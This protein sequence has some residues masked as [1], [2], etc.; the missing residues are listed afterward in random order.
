MPT[1]F[2]RRYMNPNLFRRVKN[3]V[4]PNLKHLARSEVRVCRA[5]QK[6]SVFLRFSK[7]EEFLFCVRCGANLRY[8]L[9]A[10]VIREL[11]ALGKLDI[12]E[13]DPDSTIRWMFRNARTHLRTY[14]R[15][16]H[17]RGTVREDGARMEDITNLTLA[18]ESVDF[19][20][21]SDVLEHV[22]DANA[23]FRESFRVLRPGGAHIFTVPYQRET[24]QRARI[25]DGQITHIVT[26]PEYHSDPLDPRGI[27]AYWHY[28]P[29]LDLRFGSTS[30]LEFEIVKE[31]EG[32]ANRYVWVA[33]KPSAP[34]I[35]A[36]S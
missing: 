32:I 9:L 2:L 8:E 17:S 16:E 12:L 18:D 10:E 1:A 15:S 13:L 28:G 30:G 4:L 7:H 35:I 3:R 27:L 6:R 11:G 31:P 20:I 23:A 34:T 26:P 21:S 29:D 25:V 14:Y 5:C 33:R 22:P 36:T 24:V 19:I